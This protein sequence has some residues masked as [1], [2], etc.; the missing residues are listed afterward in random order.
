MTKKLM[1]IWCVFCIAVS[2]AA[3][4]TRT[5]DIDYKREVIERGGTMAWARHVTGQDTNDLT[6]WDDFK[7]VASIP[8][9][10]GE[11]ELWVV[12]ERT[13]DGNDYTFIEQF[14]PVQWVDWPDS[15]DCWFVDCGV[16]DANSLGR[17][18]IAD[19]PAVPDTP[20]RDEAYGI[21]GRFAI[22]W[23]DPNYTQIT[24]EA[25]GGSGLCSTMDV[26][27]DTGNIVGGSAP[28]D[29]GNYL[30]FWDIDLTRDSDK[31]TP[32]DGWGNPATNSRW[33][34]CTAVRFSAD[35]NYVYALGYSV[36]L[37]YHMYKF[38]LST[39][40]DEW[41]YTR[42]YMTS[43]AMYVDAD[44]NAYY[45]KTTGGM[46]YVDADGNFDESQRVRGTRLVNDIWVDEARDKWYM[47]GDDNLSKKVLAYIEPSDYWGTNTVYFTL[48]T[49]GAFWC[50][51]SDGD[52]IYAAGSRT[53]S[54]VGGANATV[55]KFE[56]DLTLV[57]S[58]DTVDNATYLAF[59]ADGN[60]VVRTV[61]TT[62]QVILDKDL[63]LVDT[64]ELSPILIDIY[65]GETVVIPYLTEGTPAVPGTPGVEPNYVDVNDYSWLDEVCVYADGIPLGVFTVFRDAND[66]Y[67]LDLGGQYDNVIYG[68]N[69]YSIYESFPVGQHIGR[70]TQIYNVRLD[71]HETMGVNLGVSLENSSAIQFSEDDFATAIPPYTGP[72]Y[73]S[74]PRGVT[75]DPILYLWLWDPIPMS[76]R[77]LYP[78]S[79]IF[80]D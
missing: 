14:Q 37:Y 71:L 70:K 24:Q 7:S 53:A 74:F 47:A 72:K 46:E 64:F 1:I 65:G 15:N 28:N 6:V 42:L 27:G 17:D 43:Y 52:Y 78:T 58:Y 40:I 23:F 13:I 56:L 25:I 21:S 2:A 33:I 75:R 38:N 45:A 69:Y 29:E 3:Q 55:Y 8:G 5:D 35:G 67:V 16:G 61:G 80:S 32:S 59:N 49:E 39:G 41:I 30:T 36:N 22:A 34:A 73:V 11:N 19:I 76:I 62:T 18:A 10:N 31:F 48:N 44:G 77:G 20:F 4:R 26:D 60:I 12:V 57:D 50:V 68:I 66:T 9:S 63:D 79:N 51:T 54:G